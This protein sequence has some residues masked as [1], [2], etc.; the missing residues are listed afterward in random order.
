VDSTGERRIYQSRF[1]FRLSKDKPVAAKPLNNPTN[2]A[3]PPVELVG[4]T[5]KAC[6]KQSA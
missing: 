6:D 2:S 1:F 5:E 3:R 4:V